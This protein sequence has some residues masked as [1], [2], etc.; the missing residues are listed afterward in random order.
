[1]NTI[2][3]FY[4]LLNHELGESF[5]VKETIAIDSIIVD[6][7]DDFINKMKQS[8]VLNEYNQYKPIPNTTL[9]YRKDKGQP[10]VRGKE[11]HVHVYKDHKHNN[12][13]FA[14]NNDGTPHDGSKAI[15]G[16]ETAKFL[17]TL[18][19]DIPEEGAILEWYLFNG[20]VTIL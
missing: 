17:R 15:I 20:S 7:D 11:M 16:P 3:R 13:L 12:Q 19:I 2:Q 10:S 9:F 1:M 18:G 5:I 14:I 6:N 8:N 4:E